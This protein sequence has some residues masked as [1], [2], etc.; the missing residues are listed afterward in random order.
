MPLWHSGDLVV[1]VGD[2][3]KARKIEEN[4]R[5]MAEKKNKNGIWN[6]RV[7]GLLGDV[8]RLKRSAWFDRGMRR[9]K[10]CAGQKLC[11]HWMEKMHFRCREFI[12]GD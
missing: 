2:K 7:T 9:M 8:G 4:V 3:E 10:C 1:K 6:E 11:Q 5:K 12:E